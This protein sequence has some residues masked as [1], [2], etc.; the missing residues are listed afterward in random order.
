MPTKRFA[1]LPLIA[2]TEHL[3]RD[4]YALNAIG[5]ARLSYYPID[6]SATT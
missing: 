1:H 5:N 6:S 4:M 3:A 2:V